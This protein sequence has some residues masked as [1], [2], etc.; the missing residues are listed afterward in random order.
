[1][2]LSDIILIS[3]LDG[4]LVPRGGRISRENI[5]ALSELE[6]NG[7]VFSIATGRTPEAARGYVSELPITGPSVFFNGAM[8][9]DWTAGQVM[10]ICPLE[11]DGDKGL[12]PR[13]AAYCKDVLQEA[14]IEIYTEDICHIITEKAHD[15]PRLSKEFY[16]YTHGELEALSDLSK[17]PWLKFFVCDTPENLRK[18]E[19][20]AEEFGISRYAN[21]FYSEAN[22]YEFVA[23][24]ISKGSMLRS[25]REL[26]AYHGKKIIALG[27]YM[28][29]K[30]MLELADLS[31]VPQNAHEALKNQADFIGCPV[32]ENLLVWVKEH[33]EEIL[34]RL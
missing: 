17:T 3:D 9:Y 33:Q 22:Y 20:A 24:G 6:K 19:Q 23:K 14:C 26:A 34:G 31:I 32:E 1:M 28:N 15:D 16:R 21:G 13:F 2:K 30:E 25:I 11:S 8:L 27:D 18:V 4:T 5:N 7:A 10:K 29:D 12:W